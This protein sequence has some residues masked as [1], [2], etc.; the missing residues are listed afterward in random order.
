MFCYLHCLT[1]V[2]PCFALH[3]VNAYAKVGK[4]CSQAFAAAV[5]SLSGATVEAAEDAA[6]DNCDNPELANL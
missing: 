3:A 1:V 6:R 5:K 2:L 4:A